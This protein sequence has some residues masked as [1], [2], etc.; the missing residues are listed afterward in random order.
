MV[1]SDEHAGQDWFYKNFLPR[2]DS[3]L[4]EDDILNGFSDGV[5]NGNIL[6]FKT[7]VDDLNR[8]LFQAI[9]YLSAMRIKGDPVPSTILLVSFF[10]EKIYL[11][12][13]ID[14]LSDIERVYSGSASVHNSGFVCNAATGCLDLGSA[15]DQDKIVQILR[16]KSYTKVHIDENNIVGWATRY[17][18]TYP[19][20]R[21][22]DFIGDTTGAYRT[23]GEIRRPDKFRDYI[24]PYEGADNERFRY[25]MDRLNDTLQKKNLGAFYT[26]LEYAK[27]SLELVREAIHRVPEGNDYIILDRCA[28]T[29]NLEKFMTDEELS[30]CIVSTL[31]YYEYKVLLQTLGSKVR[32]IIPPIESAD[33]FNMGNVRGADAL[34]QEY[35]ENQIITQYVNNPRCSVILFENPP[36]ADTTSI[37]HQKRN[38]SKNSSLWKKSYAALAMRSEVG[39]SALNDLGNVFIWSGFRYYLRQ[40]TDS[41][42]VFSPVKYWKAQGLVNRQFIRGFAFN[43]RFFHT[44]IDACIMCAYWAN[45]EDLTLDSFNIDAYNIVEGALVSE[46][47]LPVKRIHNNYSDKYYDKRVFPKDKVGNGILCSKDGTERLSSRTVRV[48]PRLNKNIMGYMAVYSRTFDNPDNMSSLLVAGRYDGNG[49]FVRSDNFLEKMP[50]FAASRYVTY[51]R[52]WTERARIMKSADGFARF[53]AD[54]NTSRMKS[55]LLKCLLFTVLEPQNHVREFV[56][57]D[58]RT[59]LNEFTLD[60]SIRMPIAAKKILSMRK[61]KIEE[62]IIAQW[63]KVLD[64]AKTSP[65]YSPHITY[66]LYQIKVELNTSHKEGEGRRKKTVFDNPSLNG[67]I[68][69]LATMVKSYYNKEIVPFLFEYEFLK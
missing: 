23:V 66:G 29:G 59:Y 68:K 20:A 4:T 45:I 32:H 6:E 61:N 15:V 42:I 17:Y 54:I 27:K 28:G 46:G 5:V 37:E 60:C 51:N 40:P 26:G 25:L 58:G 33:T 13:S 14:Y 50:M 1:F 56:G 65:H 8:V 22:S 30:H 34:S 39:G 9:K 52:K 19:Q 62:K 63:Q 36:Y 41:Y 16:K 18:R 10:D 3:T 48:K 67:N 69:T 64:D 35:I 11:Y 38:A 2:V 44:K 31:E 24:E 21:K 57:S 55:M 47:S 43:R 12:N 53:S 7:V 49:F